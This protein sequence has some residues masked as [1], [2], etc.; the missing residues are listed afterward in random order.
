MY[1]FLILLFII[2]SI[3]QQIELKQHKSEIK[4]IPIDQLKLQ[5]NAGE[6]IGFRIGQNYVYR[7]EL[8]DKQ[9]DSVL[10]IK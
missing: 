2:V 9:I 7:P 1:P 4:P 10:Q 6:R 3:V 5:F 8:T